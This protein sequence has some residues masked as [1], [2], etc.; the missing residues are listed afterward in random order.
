MKKGLFITFEG[1]DGCGKTTQSRLLNE[2]LKQKGFDTVLSREPGGCEI[3]E[4]IREIILNVKNAAMG[5]NTEALLFAASRAQ[6]VD[7]VILPAVNSGKIVI[8]D[9]FFDSSIAYQGYG[10]QLG[11]DYILGINGYAV[12]TCPPDYTFFVEI[13]PSASRERMADRY[14]LDSLEQESRD[15][16]IRV[17]NGFEELKEKY[18][19]RYIPIDASGTP[20]E[21]QQKIRLEADRIIEKWQNS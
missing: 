19:T 16:F 21:T 9:R 17:Y 7:Q 1:I 2:Y 12:K 8:S 11:A 15:F 4:Q 18:R 5:D 20:D 13:P 10:K 14:D 3:S 6:H